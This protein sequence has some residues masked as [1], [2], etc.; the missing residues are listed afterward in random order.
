MNNIGTCGHHCLPHHHICPLFYSGNIRVDQEIRLTLL[1]MEK[2][3]NP[4]HKPQIQK[5][6][7]VTSL[8]VRLMLQQQ[9]KFAPTCEAGREGCTP[10]KGSG[11]P[12]RAPGLCAL[13][14][15]LEK[16]KTFRKLNSGPFF[17]VLNITIKAKA[18]PVVWKP[19]SNLLE[20][21]RKS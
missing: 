14:T 13:H 15:H 21:E 5:S 10:R 19:L 2:T 6:Q 7:E 3:P 11:C 16:K 18:D 9:L 17:H 8:K 12:R 1:N 20:P 4:N